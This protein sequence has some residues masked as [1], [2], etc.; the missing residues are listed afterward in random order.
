VLFGDARQ[1]RIL[2]NLGGIANATWL[3]AGADENDIRAFDTGPG[4]M[5][6]DELMQT[7]TNGR[8]QMDRDGR[9]A[10]K[11][12]ILEDVLNNW[13]AHPYFA[14]RPPKSTG[15]ETFGRAFVSAHCP[16][17][18]RASRCDDDW[19]AT[20]TRFTA[21][22]VARACRRFLPWFSGS[23]SPL[24]RSDSCDLIAAGGGARNPTLMGMLAGELPEC[25]V[26]PIDTF[27]VPNQA[28]EAMSFAVL[29]A[30][31]M[32]GVSACLPQVTGAH[33]RPLLGQVSVP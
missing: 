6:I 2:L 31:R 18:R 9:R 22:S 13:L 32:D 7:I 24:G 33:Y 30:A 23:R 8:M 1:A 20:A 21:R 27:G 16:A 28:K 11:G 17:L 10:A 26:C 25:R 12:R 19:I 29:A 5:V 4:N 14:R 3:P 15:R